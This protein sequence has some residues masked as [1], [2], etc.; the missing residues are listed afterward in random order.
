MFEKIIGFV[1]MILIV[2]FSIVSGMQTNFIAIIDPHS[3]LLVVGITMG[4]LLFAYGRS[5]SICA[6]LEPFKKSGS[7]N[8]EALTKYNAFYNLAS[9]LAI[10]AGLIGVFIGAF[11][12]LLDMSDPHAIGAGCAVALISL[13]YGLTLA[14]LILQPMK[15]AIIHNANK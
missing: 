10:G 14:T 5:F 4:G 2:S 9:I 15:Y 1:V 7:P 12:I 8:K 6:L 11:I 3:F 13:F